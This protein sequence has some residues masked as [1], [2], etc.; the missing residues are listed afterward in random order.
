MRP[1]HHRTDIQGLRAI[2]VGLVVAYHGGLPIPGGFIGVDVFFVISGYVI[3]GLLYR[4]VERSGHI[5]LLR[6]MTRRARRILPALA[7]VT[8]VTCVAA[9]FW[10]SPFG[11][12]QVT[13]GTAAGAMLFYANWYIRVRSGNYFDEA[14]DVNPLLH[15]WSLSVEEQFYFVFPSLMAV[16]WLTA[17]RRRVAPRPALV[18]MMVLV[19][20]ASL[21]AALWMTS[22]GGGQSVAWAFYGSPF[23][24]WEFAIGALVAVGVR[25]RSRLPGMVLTAMAGLGVAAI[26]ASAFL[27]DSS[28]RFPGPWTLVPVLGTAVVIYAGTGTSSGPLRGLSSRPMVWL[29]DL[30]YSWYLWHWPVIVFA[31][32]WLRDQP[33]WVATAAALSLVPAWLSFRL[34]EEPIRHSGWTG[35]TVVV[36]AAICIGV[37]VAGAALLTHHANSAVE[38]MNEVVKS[39]PARK[40]GFVAKNPQPDDLF[41]A[42]A[43]AQRGQWGVF[44]EPCLSGAGNVLGECKFFEAPGRPRAILVGDSH[45]G[46]YAAGFAAAARELGYSVEIISNGGCQVLDVPLLRDGEYDRGCAERVKE[47]WNYL[48]EDPP[49]L[50]AMAHRSPRVVSPEILLAD[51]LRPGYT[52]TCITG[53]THEGCLPHDEAVAAWASAL[54]DAA[55]TLKS[56]GVPLVVLQTAPEHSAGL[57]ECVSG[58]T[59]DMECTETDRDLTWDRRVD[60][61]EA[62]KQ[63]GADLG[64]TVYDPFDH[65]CDAET[66][67]QY[68]DDRFYYRNDDHMN[69]DGSEALTGEIKT[70]LE[71]AVS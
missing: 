28:T 5:D 12:Q 3:V 19:G 56:L 58:T 65:F 69:A 41:Q 16:V 53:S 46:A 64:F 47:T 70:A 43:L 1:T 59:V 39:Q 4:E 66:C 45:A 29:G 21:A 9:W 63:V 62:E 31:S 8:A 25:Q 27:I 57:P 24:A 54:G 67:Y 52:T 17:V 61:I 32:L 18:I 13:A 34:A 51:E 2:A 22:R 10:L 49:D 37:P 44:K 7:L 42:A 15:T 33:V 35:R 50:L 20:G 23:R 55:K 48:R 6:F 68:I 14:A 30:S 11:P 40:F 26:A 60:V 38:Q 71:E 36:L